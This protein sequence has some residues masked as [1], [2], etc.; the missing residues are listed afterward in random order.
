MTPTRRASQPE[1]TV[2]RTEAEVLAQILEALHAFGVDAER[3]NTGA[4]TNPSGKTIRFGKPGNSDITGTLPDGRRLDIEV[5]RE[6][7]DPSKLTGKKREHFDRQ[8]ARLRKTNENGGVGLWVDDAEEFMRVIL[9]LLL[10]GATVE[11]PGYGRL[12]ITTRP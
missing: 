3:Q 6:G 2:K 8:F 5:K 7:F 12:V 4:G 1:A 9:P 10:D 11:E